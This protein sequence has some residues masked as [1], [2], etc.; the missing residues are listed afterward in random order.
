MLKLVVTTRFKRDYKKAKKR[1]LDVN[2]LKNTMKDLA[3]GKKLP[4]KFRDHGLTGDY[5]DSRE[6]HLNPDWLLIYRKTKTHIHF[7]RT[8]THSDLFR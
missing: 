7:E 1:N 5:G 6:C 2:V 8:G 3:A 4:P